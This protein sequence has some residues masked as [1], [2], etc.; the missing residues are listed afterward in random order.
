MTTVTTTETTSFI[1]FCL[2][3]SP[4]V[5]RPFVYFIE[6]SLEQLRSDLYD[7]SKAFDTISH[8]GIFNKLM[9][10][11]VPLCFLKLFIYWYSNMQ[12]R[13]LWRNA[14]SNF[15]PV[16]TG[17]KQGG[18]LSP[19]IFSFYMDD[20]IRR[21]RSRGIG[22]HMLRLFLACILYADDLC[23]LAPSRGAMQE[24]LK[25]C[26]CFCDEYCLSFNVKK[27]KTLIFGDTKDQTIAPI[28][29]MNE[30]I[31]RVS[32]WVY[33][34]VTVVAGKSLSFLCKRE[35]SNYYRSFNSLLSAVQKPNELVL[36]NL[37]Y[38]NCVPCLTYAAEVKDL[39]NAEMQ[40]SNVALND[41]IRRIF[42]YNRWESTRTL[43]QQLDFPN[44]TEIFHSRREKFVSQCLRLKNRNKVVFSLASHLN[45]LPTN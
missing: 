21:L 34:G 32:Q 20:L 30:P 43:R 1:R 2:H 9:E 33:L 8:Y 25:I 38:S 45:T 16:L 10:Q 3:R 40:Q 24:M 12:T 35:L 36:M 28:L 7:C 29:L 17:T 27:S 37:L 15:F 39:S 18:V 19:Q 22:C 14:Y 23:L 26:E 41:S 44:I 11:K 4:N 42:S 5:S 31:E 13:C 6:R